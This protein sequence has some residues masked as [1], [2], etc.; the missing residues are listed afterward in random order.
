MGAK[1]ITD[2]KG[3]KVIRKDKTSKAGNPYTTYALMVSSKDTQGNWH[4]GFIECNFR[5]GVEVNNKAVIKITN[6]FPVVDEYN[7]KTTTKIFVL[8]FEVLNSGDAPVKTTDDDGFMIIPEG[9]ETET[10]FV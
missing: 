4:N 8:D 6:S 2:D 5:K 3:V 9:D 1:L 10:I 7:G